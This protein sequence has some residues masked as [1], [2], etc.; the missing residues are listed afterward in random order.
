MANTYYSAY[1]YDHNTAHILEPVQGYDIVSF[2]NFWAEMDE[3]VHG[4]F[5]GTVMHR[6][7]TTGKMSPGLTKT[8][9]AQF[10]YSK[11]DSEDVLHSPVTVNGMN[12]TSI[13][14]ISYGG[15]NTAPYQNSANKE[16]VFYGEGIASNIGPVQ[17]VNGKAQK[18]ELAPQ[19]S[20]FTTFPGACGLELGSSEFAYFVGDTT[21]TVTYKYDDALTSPLPD[22]YNAAK[23]GTKAQ[24]EFGGFLKPGT[25][26]ADNI[27]GILSQ[28][29]FRNEN[30]TRMIRFWAVYQPAITD[31]SL[32]AVNELSLSSLT[33]VDLTGATNGSVLKRNSE[34]TWVVG[35]DVDTDT[36]KT[37]EEL[38]ITL[39]E[40]VVGV[41]G[42]V[43]NT[44]AEHPTVVWAPVAATESNG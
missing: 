40:N 21:N 9:M 43:D 12:V 8:S 16:G 34:G 4:A 24:Q 38:G 22:T 36:H 13:G 20:A 18:M 32:A 3:S 42:T 14:T 31:T 29:P 35:T 41:T 30:G 23:P 2:M 27:C 7:P 15:F 44:D 17:F 33:D 10:L 19:T 1:D 28:K 39:P 5:P 37:L 6:D 26:Y 11:Q 25:H